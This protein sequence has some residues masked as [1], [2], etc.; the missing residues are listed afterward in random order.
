MEPGG[1]ARGRRN[2]S[3]VVMLSARNVWAFGTAP[4][5]GEL[6]RL[7]LALHWNGHVWKRVRLPKLPAH[8]DG[9]FS[10]VGASS[11][12]NMWAVGSMECAAAVA[13]ASRW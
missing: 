5:R 7:P 12:R 3:A 11:P 8:F 9:G 13:L 4:G 2:L 10:A 1:D 6:F